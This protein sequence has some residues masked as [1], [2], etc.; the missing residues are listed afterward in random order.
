MNMDEIQK[1]ENK[2]DRIY[3]IYGIKSKRRA[4]S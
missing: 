4:S 3:L 1:A 2:I